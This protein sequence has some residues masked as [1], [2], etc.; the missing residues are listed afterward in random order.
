MSTSENCTV[1]A[2]DQA[3]CF[4]T[5]SSNETCPIDTYGLG[6]KKGKKMVA[7]SGYTAQLSKPGSLCPSCIH[8][9][10]PGGAFDFT[11]IQERVD[12]YCYVDVNTTATP[13]PDCLCVSKTLDPVLNAIKERYGDSKSAYQQRQ[14]WYLPCNDPRYLI[15][16]SI[17]T[18][19]NIDSKANLCQT[20]S[21]QVN[22][23]LKDGTITQTEATAF[24]ARTSC[25]NLL[26]PPSSGGGGNNGGQL[27][28]ISPTTE[29]QRNYTD[30]IIL[31]SVIVIVVGF[32]LYFIFRSGS[33]KTSEPEK[34]NKISK[35][36]VQNP[37]INSKIE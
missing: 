22:A 35:I 25:T 28:P 23:L 29:N 15:S 5:A 18:N 7:C 32:V 2:I 14:K 4:K 11:E 8:L 9:R 27:E 33:E 26:S 10:G 24:Q 20:L 36:N 34:P 1:K 13:N 19:P 37:K 21:N 17:L 30:I 16:P 6:T 12:N 3:G 31:V